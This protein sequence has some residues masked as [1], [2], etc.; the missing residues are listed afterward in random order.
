MRKITCYLAL[1]LATALIVGGC[2]RDNGLPKELIGHLAAKGIKITPSRAQAPLS[3]RGGYIVA[4]YNAQ[5]VTNIVATFRLERIEQ[6]NR[7]W[8]WAIDKAGGTVA[9]KELWGV[10]GRPAQFKLKS[11]AQFEY[12]YLLITADG[13]IYLIA[14]YA[15]G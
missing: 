8:R 7:Q 1:I 10:A 6:D 3:S 4:R 2:S 15:Y 14:E 5:T 12:F 9:P 11:G 13:L